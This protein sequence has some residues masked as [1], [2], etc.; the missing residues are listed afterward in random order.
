MWI[1]P[2]NSRLGL[3]QVTS[4]MEDV[5][6]KVYEF[7]S[8]DSRTYLNKLFAKKQ[9]SNSMDIK[10]IIL[11]FIGRL[12][13]TPRYGPML[14]GQYLVISGPCIEPGAT[15]ELTF[16]SLP[17]KKNCERKTEFSMACITPM[18]PYQG[19]VIVQVVI[20]DQQGAQK[21]FLGLYTICMCTYIYSFVFQ[22]CS[23]FC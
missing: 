19:D 1:Y 15:I 21:T 12:T 8:Y 4:V 22:K 9:N 13:I 11:S 23:K 10:F 5:I 17:D 6:Q 18:F 16:V 14:G 20:E 7:D 3:M 2:E